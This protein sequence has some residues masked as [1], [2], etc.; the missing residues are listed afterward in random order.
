MLGE[1]YLQLKWAQH[2]VLYKCCTSNVLAIVCASYYFSALLLLLLF[3]IPNQILIYRFPSIF[4][5]NFAKC[6]RCKQMLLFLLLCLTK[7]GHGFFFFSSNGISI[8][9][10]QHFL[11]F[12]FHL[13]MCWCCVCFFCC[14]SMTKMRFQFSIFAL[15]WYVFEWQWYRRQRGCH[16]I[17]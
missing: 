2:Y 5:N 3:M 7:Y 11:L 8:K 10:A 12:G 15:I 4:C 6:M 16:W 9:T 17:L 14:M 1:W 13:Y